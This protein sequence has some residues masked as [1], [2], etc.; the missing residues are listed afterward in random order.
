M[1]G[2]WT[3][4]NERLIE[5]PQEF[6]RL[7]L[8]DET[9]ATAKKN[10]KTTTVVTGVTLELTEDEAYAVRYLVRNVGGT[11]SLR[12]AASRI[13]AALASA[14]I[15]TANEKYAK[16]ATKHTGSIV[17]TSYTSDLN[18]S[19]LLNLGARY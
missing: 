9:M 3:R 18:L 17:P 5:N 1:F 19:G 14:D 13:D 2:R 4:D 10:T 15:S 11:D 7:Y 6:R 8:G 12:I 16:L